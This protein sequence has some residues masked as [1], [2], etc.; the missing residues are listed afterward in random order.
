MWALNLQALEAFLFPGQGGEAA[1]STFSSLYPFSSIPPSP[2]VLFT[3]CSPVAIPPR[4]LSRPPRP[5]RPP[6]IGWWRPSPWE[7]QGEVLEWVG[8]WHG[9]WLSGGDFS[10]CGPGQRV[11]IWLHVAGPWHS[12]YI[13]RMLHCVARWPFIMLLCCTGDFFFIFTLANDYFK[14]IKT[15]MKKKGD[16]RLSLEKL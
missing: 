4:R 1:D 5:W 6:W 16:F 14:T 15:I 2:S 10:C 13:G 11:K 8:E 7:L 3:L 9:Q 12:K